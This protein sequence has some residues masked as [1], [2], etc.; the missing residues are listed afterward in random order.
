MTTIS[1]C[2]KRERLL[3]GDCRKEDHLRIEKA[4]VIVKSKKELQML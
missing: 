2:K 1:L 3:R 4:V